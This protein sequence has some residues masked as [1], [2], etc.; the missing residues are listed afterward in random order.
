MI[1]LKYFEK[2]KKE[3][4]NSIKYINDNLTELR[5]GRCGAPILKETN[6]DVYPYQCLNCDENKFSFEVRKS[7]VKVS[8]NE[9]YTILEY[10][11]NE[12]NLDKREE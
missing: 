1:M 8:G 12:L 3:F 2:F 7:N 4:P 5:C 11:V 10:V 6:T 9:L